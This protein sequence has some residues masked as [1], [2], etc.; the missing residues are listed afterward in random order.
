MRELTYPPAVA[1]LLICT[2]VAHSAPAADE[3]P[4]LQVVAQCDEHHYRHSEGSAIQTADRKVLLVWSQFNGH[5]DRCGTLGDNGPATLVMAESTDGGKSWTD[6]RELPVGTATVNIMQAAFVPTRDRLMLAFSVRMKEGRTSVKHAIESKD[7]GRTWTERRKLFDAGGANDRAVRLSTGRI[8]MPSHRRSHK[9]IGQDD[10]IEVLVARSDDEGVSWTLTE[11]IPHKPHP[12]ELKTENPR[13]VKIN[14]PTIAECPDG[15]LLM[16]T[17]SSVGVLYASRS[18]DGGVTWSELEPTNIPSFAAPPYMR[19]LR[20]GRLALLWNP[21][22]GKG[23]MAK[24]EEALK[25][26][27]PVP[28][29]RRERLALMTSEDGGKSW[30]EPRSTVEDGKYGYCYPW[31]LQRQDDSLI[32]FCSRTPYTIYPCDL[33]QLAPIRP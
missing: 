2:F 24:T 14:E 21:I 33:V 12:M 25:N 3:L 18:T 9:R 22:A 27:T 6:T 4:N 1:S 16:L 20:D 11:P 13:S 26:D 32:I 31:M 5:K 17:R 8:L 10:D 19:R 29:G 28:Y 30:S 15:S 7:S 23:G